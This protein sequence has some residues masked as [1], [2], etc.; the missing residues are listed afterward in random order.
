MPNTVS[1]PNRDIVNLFKAL[2]SLDGRPEPVNLRTREGGEE[3]QL[4]LVPY[5]FSGKARLALAR[6]L[7]AVKAANDVLVQ[8][9]DSLVRE[10]GSAE[11]V[12]PLR[13]GEFRAE[14]DKAL[15]ESSEFS[16]PL[17]QI[18]DLKPEENKIPVSLLAVLSPVLA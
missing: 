15:D 13:V 17:V 4:I 18:E 12:D 2:N 8:A 10:F 9:H 3:V 16:L 6:W 1:I 7:T 11:G 14:W 5:S